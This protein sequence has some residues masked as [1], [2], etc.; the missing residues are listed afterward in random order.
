MDNTMTKNTVDSRT[1]WKLLN[2]NKK[3]NCKFVIK[4]LKTGKEYTYRIVRN[5]YNEK[6]YTHVSVETGYN[7][8]TRLG[9]FF[10]KIVNK[11]KEVESPSAI[12]ISFVLNKMKKEEF[13]YLDKNVEFLHTG[14]CLKCGKTLTDSDSIKNGFGPT[15]MRFSK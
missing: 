2:I 15:C 14:V 3:V 1:I 4:S 6:W 12:A 10:D 5:E 13:D 11:G 7:N 8:F 9:T